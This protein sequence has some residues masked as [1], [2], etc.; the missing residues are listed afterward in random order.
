MGALLTQ[1]QSG[2]VWNGATKALHHSKNSTQLS[3]GKFMASVF[4]DSERVI[5]VDFLPRGVAINAQYYSNFLHNDVHQ[6]IWKRR[7]GKL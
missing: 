1:S 4:W 6:D 7:P 3:A 2:S 5:D